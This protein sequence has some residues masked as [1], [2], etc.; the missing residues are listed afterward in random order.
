MRPS[1][2]FRNYKKKLHLISVSH[3][4]DIQRLMDILYLN[5]MYNQVFH[6]FGE[7]S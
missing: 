5:I 1:S 3:T 2:K 7:N 4:S 6:C